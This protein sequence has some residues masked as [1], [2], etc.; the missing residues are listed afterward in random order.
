MKAS[1]IFDNVINTIDQ[2][3]TK[4]DVWN[5][6]ID[7]PE[8][9]RSK[10]YLHSLFRDRMI[11]Q[12]IVKENDGYHRVRNIEF[13]TRQSNNSNKKPRVP[14]IEKQIDEEDALKFFI[15][16][17]KKMY[18]LGT[19]ARIGLPTNRI[20]QYFIS[21]DN[22]YLNPFNNLGSIQFIYKELA[23]HAQNGTEIGNIVKFTP[24]QPIEDHIAYVTHNYSI[25]IPLEDEQ[26]FLSHPEYNGYGPDKLADLRRYYQCLVEIQQFLRGCNSAMDVHNKLLRRGDDPR[27]M[28][29]N[30]K[31]D[32]KNCYGVALTFDFIKE[33]GR[34]HEFTDLDFPKPDLHVK[35]TMMLAFNDHIEMNQY[36]Y[37][38]KGF[39]QES[40]S[41][42]T[43]ID[44]H[45]KMVELAKIAYTNHNGQYPYKMMNYVLDKAIYV[46]CSGKFYVD[47]LSGGKKFG[48]SYYQDVANELYKRT[49]LDIAFLDNFL[50]R[51]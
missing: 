23:F 21:T 27:Q 38:V 46:V 40:I 4:D 41:G 1:R 18:E 17:I 11:R 51:L 14:F 2:P 48:I 36:R 42:Y 9:D 29:L 7:D 8:W 47:N 3:F 28:F 32:I 44:L 33:F 13:A 43:T 35:R 37:N 15:F 6:L 30:L 10:G 31:E 19:S 50:S 45:Q 25:N 39:D 34:A 16:T 22:T 5:A 20:D 12:F 24:G 49:P 26:I